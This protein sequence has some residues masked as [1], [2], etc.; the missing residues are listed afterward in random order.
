[1]PFADDAGHKVWVHGPDG[2]CIDVSDL[3]EGVGTAACA[4][5]AVDD[6]TDPPPAA[7]R[8]HQHAIADPDLQEDRFE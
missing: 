1:M 2:T 3:E 4:A 6:L 7:M 8:L 5:F